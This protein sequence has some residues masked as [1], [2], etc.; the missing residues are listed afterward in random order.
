MNRERRRLSDKI[1]D[2]PRVLS[3]IAS[4]PWAIS[5]ASFAVTAVLMRWD[6]LTAL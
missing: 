1:A 4:S 3:R 2:L 6:S 5:F